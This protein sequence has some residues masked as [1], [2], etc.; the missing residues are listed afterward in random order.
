M[1]QVITQFWENCELGPLPWRGVCHSLSLKVLKVEKTNPKKQ[2]IFWQKYPELK[3]NTWNCRNLNR[4]NEMQNFWLKKSEIRRNSEKA[5]GTC[6]ELHFTRLWIRI[7]WSE[8]NQI[9][10]IQHFWQSLLCLI[11]FKMF[12]NLLFAFRLSKRPT[13]VTL[14]NTQSWRQLLEKYRKKL[15]WWVNQ[16]RKPWHLLATYWLLSITQQ[17]L[18]LI[19]PPHFEDVPCQ[20]GVNHIYEG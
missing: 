16:S 17:F 5:R 6:N 3:E 18:T 9:I 8:C 15:F 7:I 14:T 11:K 2:P 12:W 20:S 4:K 13:S 19:Y 10:L 1:I